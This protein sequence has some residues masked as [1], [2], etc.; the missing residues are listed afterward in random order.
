MSH[1]VVRLITTIEDTGVLL[2]LCHEQSHHDEILLSSKAIQ[3]KLHAKRLRPNALSRKW[4]YE[5]SC[6]LTEA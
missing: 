4:N 2:L 1:S 5:Y 3:T 6:A